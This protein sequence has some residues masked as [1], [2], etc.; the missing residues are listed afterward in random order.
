MIAGQIT[1][2]AEDTVEESKHTAVTLSFAGKPAG[3]FEF[4]PGS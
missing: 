1:S 3:P 4:P 2:L